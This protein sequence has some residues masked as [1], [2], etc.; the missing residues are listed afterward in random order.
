MVNFIQDA[1][2]SCAC[3]NYKWRW[4]A[5]K[6]IKTAKILSTLLLD[7]N[8]WYSNVV[9]ITTAFPVNSRNINPKASHGDTT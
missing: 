1:T 8:S 3:L 4:F 7:R 5:S 6:W 9:S 2:V